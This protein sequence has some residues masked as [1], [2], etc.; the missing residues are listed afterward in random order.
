MRQ[1]TKTSRDWNQNGF[2][3]NVRDWTAYRK[4]LVQ[5]TKNIEGE[6]L[7]DVDT[8]PNRLSPVIVNKRTTNVALTQ[9]ER[10]EEQ[11]FT[12]EERKRKATAT[13]AMGIIKKSTSETVY[14]L[15]QAI[16]MLP[17]DVAA[18]TVKFGLMLDMMETRFKGDA[19]VQGGIIE[20]IEEEMSAICKPASTD[21]EA[22]MRLHQLLKFETELSNFANGA[23]KLTNA[24]LHRKAGL[25]LQHRDFAAVRRRMIEE[26]LGTVSDI[27][28]VHLEE[29]AAERMFYGAGAMADPPGV[30]FA[31][32]PS[33]SSSSSSLSSSRRECL[34][35]CQPRGGTPSRREC[36]AKSESGGTPSW[37]ESL[38]DVKAAP[39]PR[40]RERLDAE[41]LQ[42]DLGVTMSE[43]WADRNRVESRHVVRGVWSRQTVR[44]HVT[45]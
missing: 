39:R 18:A 42:A 5:E 35:K 37:R 6:F 41:L 40:G 33:S 36:L 10:M 27:I 28:R 12:K 13:K 24:K 2:S 11:A 15:L 38:V 4:W 26:D 21:Q 9:D 29:A 17:A 23:G 34:A 44:R 45:S 22:E 43:R 25:I 8:D 30:Q 16:E 31:L 3:G 7:V 14:S 32:Q 20:Q 1:T 19:R